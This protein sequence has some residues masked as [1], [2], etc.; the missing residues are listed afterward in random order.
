DGALPSGGVR[1]VE[2]KGF[3]E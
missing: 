1:K 3:V 2:G